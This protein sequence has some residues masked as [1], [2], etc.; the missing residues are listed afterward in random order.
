MLLFA[1]LVAL[2]A[3]TGSA[4]AQA[5]PAKPIRVIVPYVAGGA[6]DITAR[7]LSQKLAESLGVSVIV[8]NRPGANG[9]IGTDI[10]A[11]AAPDGYTLLL[12]ASGPVVVNPVLYS[13]VPY[14][15]ENDFVPIASLSSSYGIVEARK[16]LPANTMAELIV[17]GTLG[18]VV[19]VGGLLV[20][21][22]YLDWVGC[23]RAVHDYFAREERPEAI[24][25]AAGNDAYVVKESLTSR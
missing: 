17:P 25:T 24:R 10:V 16:D 9:G 14:D 20:I 3:W 8:D 22:D 18:I 23:R 6:A 21:D 11:K 1:A 19:D 12:D 5:Y 2:A 4:R 13:K 15:P 7:T